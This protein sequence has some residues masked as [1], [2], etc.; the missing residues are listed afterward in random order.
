M[1]ACPARLRPC[2]M[3]TGLSA[4]GTSPRQSPHAH[5]RSPHASHTVRH[6]VRGACPHG[7]TSHQMSRAGIASFGIVV[8]TRTNNAGVFT[9]SLTIWWSY[10]HRCRTTH[11]GMHT[12]AGD[13]C[14]RRTPHSALRTPHSALRTAHS[15]PPCT[16]R[17]GVPT[18]LLA[19]MRNGLPRRSAAPSMV[20]SSSWVQGHRLQ[21]LKAVHHVV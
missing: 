2:A 15:T 16:V 13:A 12:V 9:W 6:S 20:S 21:R 3:S 17:T 14:T 7:V 4:A 19:K 1:Y 8:K 10:H 5:A 18:I 11:E